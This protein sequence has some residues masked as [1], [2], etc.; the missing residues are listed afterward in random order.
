MA[1]AMS[2]QLAVHEVLAQR[3]SQPWADVVVLERLARGGGAARW[4]MV[5]TPKD[6]TRVYGELRAGS[7]VSFYFTGGPNV[8]ADDEPTRQ[9]MFD[10]IT[11]TGEIVLGYP[12]DTDV[13]LQVDVISG[14]SELTEQ[15]M[16]QPE[17]GQVV[18]GTWP[19]PLN[20]GHNAVTVDLVDE[21]GVL[22]PHP[23]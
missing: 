3:W 15:L 16:H 4:F 13:V 2:L 6:V 7:R 10:E 1:S 20:D 12:S 19:S 8:D 9:R 11:S 22:R 21:D 18:W 14:P 17:G 23:H 5:R